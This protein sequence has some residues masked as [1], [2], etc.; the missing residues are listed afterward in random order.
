M[1]DGV[2]PGLHQVASALDGEDWLLVGGAMTQLHCPLN[3]VGYGRSTEDVDV[4]VDPMNHSTLV[5]VAKAVSA[6]H[7]V[8]LPNVWSALA[9]KSHALRLPDANRERHVQDALALLA[10]ADRTEAKRELTKSERAGVNKILSS[11]YLSAVENWMP[12]DQTHWG[13][14]LQEMRRLRPQGVIP[15]PPL[16]QTEMPLG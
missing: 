4:V 12:L 5:G 3:D 16:L 6:A 15:V 10:C 11:S 1:M 2:Y 14:A 8:R 7:T 13:E 9:M